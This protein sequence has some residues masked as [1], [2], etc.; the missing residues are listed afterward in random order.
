MAGKQREEGEGRRDRV[1]GSKGGRERKKISRYIG[2]TS[3]K[4]LLVQCQ[5]VCASY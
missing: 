2:A 4:A 3:E 5:A 1:G